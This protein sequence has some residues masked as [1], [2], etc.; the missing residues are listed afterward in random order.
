MFIGATGDRERY[1]PR[2]LDQLTRADR[3]TFEFCAEAAGRLGVVEAVPLL[4]ERLQTPAVK[5][6]P[7]AFGRVIEAVS[8]VGGE[9]A[10]AALWSLLE[11]T[12]PAD[13]AIGDVAQAVLQA[14]LPDDIDRFVQWYRPNVPAQFHPRV[15][16]PIVELSGVSRLYDELLRTAQSGFDDLID[17]AEDWLETELPLA[18]ESAHALAQIFE[19]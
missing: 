3:S 7:S 9:Q 6:N 11:H 14:A 2:V 18:D 19:D 15:L 10:R 5:N 17:L 12:Q 8:R 13:Y 4:I 1:G 16:R